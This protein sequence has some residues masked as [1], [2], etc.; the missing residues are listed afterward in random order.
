MHRRNFITNTA[1]AAFALF[2]LGISS[3]KRNPEEKN[4]TGEE[5][6]ADAMIEVAAGTMDWISCFSFLGL[7]HLPLRLPLLLSLPKT[8]SNLQR[9]SSVTSFSGVRAPVSP[10]LM[11]SDS[12]G[13]I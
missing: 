5:K 9:F 7:R 8:V 12:Q 6:M 1:Q 13:R 2:V 10:L 11:G 3:C 4:E